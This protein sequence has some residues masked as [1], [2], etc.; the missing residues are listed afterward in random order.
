VGVA[1]LVAADGLACIVILVKTKLTTPVPLDISS[2][3]AR[4]QVTIG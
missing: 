3:H 2:M 4:K 1:L